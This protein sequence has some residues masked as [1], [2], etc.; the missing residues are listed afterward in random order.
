M[1]TTSEY[2][3]LLT[4][5]K[6]LLKQKYKQRTNH[7]LQCLTYSLKEYENLLLKAGFSKIRFFAA[8]PD[9]KLPEKIYSISGDH[10]ECRFNKFVLKGGYIKEHDGSNGGKLENQNE[11]SSMY[12]S[13][14]EMNIAHFFVQ[15]SS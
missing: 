12:K 14:A 3:T 1:T 10:K 11:I 8:L 5:Q 15:V 4:L 13:L 2:Q 9:Y 6:N 7:E